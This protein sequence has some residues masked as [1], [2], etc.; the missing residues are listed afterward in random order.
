MLSLFFD[1]LDL[2]ILIRLPAL[3]ILD[4]DLDFTLLLRRMQGDQLVFLDVVFACLGCAINSAHPEGELI[5][6][7]FL[8]SDC[9]R[10]V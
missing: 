5:G 4:L 6:D 3:V 2:E 1:K 9:D 10:S 8:N 7:L